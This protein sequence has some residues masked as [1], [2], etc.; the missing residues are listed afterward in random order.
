MLTVAPPNCVGSACDVAV[1]VKLDGSG[2]AVGEVYKPVVVTVPK[3][4]LAPPGGMPFT[5]QL[6]PELL[7][8]VTVALNC[9]VAVHWESLIF[10]EACAGET[11]TPT[12]MVTLADADFVLSACNIAVTVTVA[13]EGTTEG[14]VYSPE[15]SIVPDVAFP[16]LVP[17]TCQVTAALLVPWTIARKV[18]WLAAFTVARAGE[19]ETVTVGVG[20]GGGGGAEP[21]PH[22]GNSRNGR[23]APSGK[24]RLRTGS[25]PPFTEF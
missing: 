1:T 16:P 15:V 19:M 9:C 3:A 10:R 18:I 21:P 11:V 23:S 8:P 13:G 2:I 20:G 14:A 12:V 6:T 17:F 5:A 4:V 25:S 22:P 24:R 7:V